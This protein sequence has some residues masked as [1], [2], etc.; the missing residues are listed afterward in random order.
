MSKKR[1]RLK[2][3]TSAASSLIAIVVGLLAGFLILLISNPSRA[4]EGLW[5]I[6]Q[7]GFNNGL[8]GMGQVLYYATPIIV[9][10]L[11][12]GFAF[13]TGLFNI[14]APGQL[15][16]GG[17]VSVLVGVTCPQLGAIHWVVALLCGMAAG[18]LWGLVPGLFKALLN[19][20]EV[21]SSIMMNY[22]GLYGINYLIKNL[23]A[24]E[25]GYLIYDKL[26]NQTMN[27]AE[28]AV[29]PKW[30]LDQV[31][32]NMKGSYMD[33]SSVNAGIFLAIFLAIVMY[34][35]LNKTTFGYE[36]K[37]CGLNKNASNYAG[38]N[39]NRSVVLSMMIAGALSGAAG[40]LMY[41]A[42]AS[43]MH[44]HVEEVLSA[45]GFNGIPVALLGL[46]NPIGIIFSGLFVAYITVGG[47]YLQSLKYMK[48]IIDVIIG[49]IIYFSA[50]SLFVKS[51]L[52]KRSARQSREVTK[53]TVDEPEE[54]EPTTVEE[55]D[56]LA[57][58]EMEGEND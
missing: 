31:F 49:I 22:I 21:I 33:A 4:G 41:L 17:F 58:K 39:G 5:V 9:T 54:N 2:G 38:I 32:Y 47:S 46:S 23:M 18:A 35:V 57:T 10:G 13:K 36:L 45:Q 20:N 12:V 11:S 40:A 44:I 27:V 14:G 25:G 15:M 55:A 7:G 52:A 48:E 3:M 34:I 16:V 26:K 1:F 29:L 42:P 28:S 8:K 37:A 51:I 53:Q 43:G 56:E 30:G 24:P 19:V 6:L 50:F